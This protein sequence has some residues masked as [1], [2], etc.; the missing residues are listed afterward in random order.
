MTYCFIVS[1]INAEYT[2]KTFL[3]ASPPDQ[4]RVSNTLRRSSNS[5]SRMAKKRDAATVLADNLTLLM[6]VK[7][8][9]SEPELEKIS[10]VAQKTINNIR[11]KR[12]FPKLD[13]IEK[14]ADAFGMQVHQLLC[15]LEDI[16]FL[17]VC[18]AWVQ[19][20]ERGR[21]DLHAIA[22][23]VLKTRERSET[24]PAD[25]ITSTHLR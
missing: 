6:Q 22:E 19:S 5:L 4:G 23:A 3:N 14:L 24:R 8:I 21:D 18:L 1:M 7:K 16:K 13:T 15:P 12:N 25:R 10:D 20:D 9:N 11:H 17:A 2:S